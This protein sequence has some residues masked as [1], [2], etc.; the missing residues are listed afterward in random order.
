[1]LLAVHQDSTLAR[2]S[3]S[4]NLLAVSRTQGTAQLAI[5][6]VTPDT[7]VERDL[8]LTIVAGD[9]AAAQCGDLRLTHTLPTVRTLNTLRTPTLLYNSQH[10]HP[11]PLV[12][13]NV[14]LPAGRLVPDRVVANLYINNVWRAEGAW[15]GGDW[16]PGASRRIA[17]GFDSLQIPTGI[18]NYRLEL[19]L[20]YDEAE[21]ARGG[22]AAGAFHT[23]GL[24]ANGSAFCW[25]RNA[26]G[27]LGLGTF[28]E[29]RSTPSAV[30]GGLVFTTLAA[31]GAHTCG[32]TASGQAYC[33]GANTVGQLGDGTTTSRN[34]P[35]AVAGGLTFSSIDAGWDVTC[36]VTTGN[37]AYCWGGN[38][39]GELGDGTTT[40]KST[41]TPVGGGLAVDRIAVGYDHTCALTPAG[42]AH[43]WGKNGS[44]QLGDGT[45]GQTGTEQSLSPVPVAGG[46]TYSSIDL[47]VAHTCAIDG[48][49]GLRC[50][51]DDAVHQLGV[52]PVSPQQ[53]AFSTFSSGCARMPVAVDSANRYKAVALGGAH[54]CA[55]VTA[56][57][58]RCWGYG[59]AGRVGDGFMIDRDVPTAVASTSYFQALAVGNAHACGLTSL[60]EAYCWGANDHYALGDGSTLHRPTPTRTR[61]VAGTAT[62]YQQSVSGRLAI[63]NRST[64]PF[65]AG[66][67]L[68]GLEQLDPVSMLWVGGDGSLRS[69]KPAGTNRW[70]APNVDRPDTLT[71]TGVNYVRYLPHGVQVLFDSAGRHIATV[72]RLGHRTSFFYTGGALDSIVVPPATTRR[73]YRFVYAGG[74]LDSIIAPPIDSLPR[75]VDVTASGARIATIRDPDGASVQFVTDSTF[76]NRIAARVSRLGD[77]TAFRFD[78][79]GKL[80]QVIVPVATGQAPISTTYLMAESRSAPGSL[81]ARSLLAD[82][83]ATL[84]NGP[85]ADTTVTRFLVGRFGAPR[86]I[87]DALGDSTVLTRAHVTYPA[88]VTQSR[89]P[90]GFLTIADYDNRGN[91]QTLTQHDP[92]GTGQNA[93]TRYEWDARWDFVRKIVPPEG[94][95]LIFAYDTV[96]NRIKQANAVGDSVVFRYANA[97]GLLSSSQAMLTPSDSL[98]YDVLGNLS[99]SRTP[100]GYWTSWH[101]DDLGRDTLVVSAISATDTARSGTTAQRHRQRTVYDVMDQALLT[102]TIAP[103][104]PGTA[105]EDTARVRNEYDL[106]G[107]LVGLWRMA[108]PD[109]NG[110]D[111]LRTE[112]TYDRAGRKTSEIAPDGFADRWTLD[113]A[114]NVTAWRTRRGHFIRSTYDALNR[115]VLRIVPQVDYSQEAYGGWRFPLEYHRQGTAALRIPADTVRFTYA[116]TGGILTAGNRDARIRRGYFPNGALRTDTLTIASWD[117]TDWTRH[118]YGLR[119]AYDLNGRRTTLWGPTQLTPP[120]DSPWEAPDTTGLVGG[121]TYDAAGR[122]ATVG[123]VRMFYDRESRLDSIAYSSALYEKLIYDG[124]GRLQRRVQRSSQRDAWR[125]RTNALT[126]T[127]DA[128]A[129]V[130]DARGK[131][132]HASSFADS[133][134]NAYTGLGALHRATTTPL[135]TGGGDNTSE[136]SI[137]TIE[138]DALGQQLRTDLNAGGASTIRDYEYAKHHGRLVRIRSSNPPSAGDTIAYDDAG[139][140]RLV[141]HEIRAAARD[142]SAAYVRQPAMHYYDA[143]QRLR[144][145]DKRS[146]VDGA[147]QYFAPHYL[148]TFEE[149]RYDAL[150]RRI[151]LWARRDSSGVAEGVI[152]RFVWDGDQLLYETRYPAGEADSLG[153][154]DADS[155]T[156]KHK[157]SCGGANGYGCGT[158]PD[159]VKFLYT[160]HR[161][162]SFG[163]M[164]YL[165][166]AGIDRP[167]RITRMGYGRDTLEFGPIPMTPLSNW[168]GQYARGVFATGTEELYYRHPTEGWSELTARVEID[169][170][171]KAVRSFLDRKAKARP[172][173]GWF[174]GL[175]GG[176]ESTTGL[177]YMRNRYY[178]PVQGRF[179][180]E[181]PIGL[182]GGLNLYGFAAGD[183]VNHSDPFG[184]C[185]DPDDPACSIGQQ[186]VNAAR[187]QGRALLNT[188][189]DLGNSMAA[190]LKSLATQAGIELATQGVIAATTGGAGNV[191]IAVTRR[192][193]AH[194]MARHFPGGARTAGKSIFNAA[195]NLVDLVRGAEGVAPVRQAGGNFQRVV[196]AGREV[197]VDRASGNATNV[198][199]VITNMANELVT[200][201]P[202]TP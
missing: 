166:G 117:R 161:A 194:V 104:E 147:I 82:S 201:F 118:Q 79:A 33:W 121:Y 171:G 162:A 193:A 16:Q 20:A 112:W 78:A 92:L 5:A 39:H 10:A 19:R 202:G 152:Q 164:Q 175:I 17:L 173:A 12:S 183:P 123:P 3:G 18:V 186:V 72:S 45:G 155:A 158:D 188:L 138:T 199:T 2:D 136:F 126:D 42:A 37:A 38:E 58:A 105:S 52:G 179:T 170:P 28:T 115:P 168:R 59:A 135:W 133:I 84:V 21:P 172:D 63:V 151:F 101:R 129:Y 160:Y 22:I 176:H 56:D 97:F 146:S 178:D 53:C 99:A 9:D 6:P 132:T 13:A 11:F 174:G 143:E 44:G 43:C 50:W 83:A 190:G 107:R 86:R 46:H 55:L 116:V 88:L 140:V 51:G 165:H 67:W 4:V 90:N 141:D 139:N 191:G 108:R 15:P 91:V 96:G 149:Y 131:L 196:T 65:G 60:G 30:T 68:A 114:G 61:G 87:V 127:I 57:V 70:A 93:T 29:S 77:T 74:V 185:P 111:S 167:L 192:G 177:L 181:D 154:R 23:C 1:V 49:N 69:Y 130:H 120:P 113:P 159:S 85:R 157:R 145:V 119:Y 48:S 66:W 14:T 24:G 169:W 36:A 7:V 100:M 198:Y 110:I 41:P 103:S 54:S 102:E 197:G 184:L 64:S 142:G 31:G 200:M 94:D 27:Q 128:V 40:S 195:E 71:W 134:E 76:T 122:L 32:L 106:A 98:E 189:G 34:T 89:A 35:V 148:G 109:R 153:W 81:T 75:V 25:G 144:V 124:D 8:C 125:N 26:D 137:E 80:A 163:R 187:A 73:V 95:S 62:S 150:G 180:Q 156:V 47:G 182:A